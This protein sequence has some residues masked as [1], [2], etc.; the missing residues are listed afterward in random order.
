LSFKT[1]YTSSYSF[2]WFLSIGI[3]GV[4]LVRFQKISD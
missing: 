2:F 4:R 3:L 1:L